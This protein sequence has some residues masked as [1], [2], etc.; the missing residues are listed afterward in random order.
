MKSTVSHPYFPSSASIPGYAPNVTP[1]TRLLPVFGAIIGA[2]AVSGHLLAARTRPRLRPIDRF[3]VIWFAVCE[4][5]CLSR[6][7]EAVISIGN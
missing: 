3:A 1:L 7:F 4:L 5:M 6:R 2:V